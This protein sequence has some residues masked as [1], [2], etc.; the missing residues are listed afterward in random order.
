MGGLGLSEVLLLSVSP[1]WI[2]DDACSEVF[3]DRGGLVG[4]TRVDDQNF[5]GE[6]AHTF[7]CP[8]DIFLFIERNNCDA[9]GRTWHLKKLA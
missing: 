8:S 9:Q 1:P 3:R 4:G 2:H 5:L 7:D 6:P